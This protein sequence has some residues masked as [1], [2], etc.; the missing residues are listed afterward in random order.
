MLAAPLGVFPRD[1]C[2]RHG[3]VPP[4][5]VCAAILP[6]P[7]EKNMLQMLLSG[8]MSEAIEEA[9]GFLPSH[10]LRL[11]AIV[12]F[13]QNGAFCTRLLRV[14]SQTCKPCVRK[15]CESKLPLAASALPLVGYSRVGGRRSDAHPGV[16]RASLPSPA[17]SLLSVAIHRAVVGALLIAGYKLQTSGFLGLGCNYRGCRAASYFPL[18]ADCSRGFLLVS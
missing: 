7:E 4:V 11:R 14:F 16:C 1:C 6:N 2:Q 13:S 12:V 5:P 8:R 15:Q 18:L 17:T 9:G 3:S 10:C